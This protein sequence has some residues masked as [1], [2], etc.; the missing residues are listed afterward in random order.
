MRVKAAEFANALIAKRRYN[1]L[2]A[3]ARSGG[4][5]SGCGCG[6]S[7]RSC[8]SSV[9]RTATYHVEEVELV[10]AAVAVIKCAQTVDFVRE[11]WSSWIRDRVG[12]KQDVGE[13]AFGW[14]D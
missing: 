12:L 3:T 6:R 5:A 11:A 13:F 1:T 10:G 8:A 7:G 14:Q 4:A 2:I 9:R